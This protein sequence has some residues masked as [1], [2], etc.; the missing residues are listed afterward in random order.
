MQEHA[1][2]D[3]AEALAAAEAEAKEAA[4][5]AAPAATGERLF[6]QLRQSFS[7]CKHRPVSIYCAQKDLPG[8]S[9]TIFGN[10]VYIPGLRWVSP[11]KS[12]QQ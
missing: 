8:T 12:E 9:H 3:E 2:A 6:L 4:Q 11:I 5:G 10:V 1:G 7:S